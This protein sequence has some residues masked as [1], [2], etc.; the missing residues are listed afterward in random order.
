[1]HSDPALH[2]AP[3]VVTTGILS[4]LYQAYNDEIATTQWR[5]D[6]QRARL[7]LTAIYPNEHMRDELWPIATVNPRP[8]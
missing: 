1:M 7:L 8:A 6:P 5:P 2:P 3:F 4:I